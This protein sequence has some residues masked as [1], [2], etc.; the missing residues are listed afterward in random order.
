MLNLN[1][2]LGILIRG[3]SKVDSY[4]WLSRFGAK[5]FR[6]KNNAGDIGLLSTKFIRCFVQTR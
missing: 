6:R 5:K 3:R 2:T 1:S 4:C